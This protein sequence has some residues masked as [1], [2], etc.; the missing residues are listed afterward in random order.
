MDLDDVLEDLAPRLLRFT[1][2]LAG[3]DRTLAEEASQDALT[4][5][6]GRWRTHGPPES[7]EAFAF[8]IARR[9]LGRAW[10][11]RRWN[12]G[13]EA[14]LGH[15]DD[16]PGPE[17]RADQRQSLRHTLD[18][19]D[20]LPHRLREALLL[21]AAGELSVAEAAAVLDISQSA[22]KMRVSRARQQLRAKLENHPSKGQ[23]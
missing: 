12:D 14:L 16:R 3:G 21:I 7:P 17:H 23:P 6:V 10:W 11:K 2:G 5:L 22:L 15:P 8:A 20:R 19:V 13:V 9:R 4:A 18:A 1:V